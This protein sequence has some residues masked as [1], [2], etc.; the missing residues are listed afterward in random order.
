MTLGNIIKDY[1]EANNI[2]MEEF[3]KKSRLS[4]SYIS[5]L[6]QNKDYRGNPIKPS[7]ETIQKVADTVGM[8][9]DDI[10]RTIDQDIVINPQ[11]RPDEFITRD[12]EIIK[13]WK[14]IKHC[15]EHAP[16]TIQEQVLELL[17]VRQKWNEYKEICDLLI[18]D[19]KSNTFIMETTTKKNNGD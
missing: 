11:T 14:F 13:K 6:E 9:F 12:E 10:I 15:Y 7:V 8:G 17:K 2:T 1:R 4:K 3:S 16:T 18:E 19:D 5:M